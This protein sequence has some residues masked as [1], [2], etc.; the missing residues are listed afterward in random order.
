[1]ESE[2]L[3]TNV[4][5]Y[6]TNANLYDIL[7]EPESIVQ[8]KVE[9]A[10][11]APLAPPPL[12]PSHALLQS[13]LPPPAPMPPPLPPSHALLQ[14][15]LPPPAPM[16]PP[17]TPFSPDTTSSITSDH[18]TSS[19]ATV[20]PRLVKIHWGKLYQDFG[21][22][23][24]MNE[25]L[26]NFPRGLV[27]V[28]KSVWDNLPAVDITNHRESL[29]MKFSEHITVSIRKKDEPDRELLRILTEKD[30]QGVEIKIKKFNGMTPQELQTKMMCL[31]LPKFVTKLTNEDRLDMLMG[32]WRQV[33]HGKMK[34][35]YE[36]KLLDKELDEKKLEKADLFLYQ[37]YQ[38]PN[39]S[40][41][42]NIVELQ[43]E[44]AKGEKFWIYFRNLTKA[45]TEIRS[46]E[47]LKYLISCVLQVGKFLNN[48]S[49]ECHGFDLS[50]LQ[51]YIRGF[52]DKTE[53]SNSLGVHCLKILKK[54]KPSINFTKQL[55]KE[56]KTVFI[57]TE[58]NAIKANDVQNELV[59]W[60]T[61]SR[62]LLDDVELLE[63]GPWK[64]ILKDA[65]RLITYNIDEL[66]KRS[67]IVANV[68]LETVI[69]MSVN[70]MKDNKADNPSAVLFTPLAV[71]VRGTLEENKEVDEEAKKQI[72]GKG[73]R[74][75]FGPKKRPQKAQNQDKPG[76][77]DEIKGFK[78]SGL[79]HRKG[80]LYKKISKQ[81]QIK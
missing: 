5:S 32:I 11:G 15:P 70:P 78:K 18:N 2:E 27:K 14:S 58:D 20:K 57:L 59:R 24:L 79:H 19:I 23:S 22:G 3:D 67:K 54:E 33:E 28:N 26:S 39:F 80:K 43:Q 17:P 55:E 77:L 50:K 37:L 29:Q 9:P 31:S 10:N 40:L 76:V 30:R 12:P 60:K 73:L 56:L 34:D 45:C 48:A 7:M 21:V 36:E 38:I 81:T 35:E 62:K 1:M 13:P 46:S 68:Y 69:Y 4:C 53:T 63:P 51:D 41:Y 61:K 71:F 52:K 44:V 6:E 42:L 64:E 16:P 25:R 47:A 74:N 65:M 72:K 66:I 8:T 49:D 75:F